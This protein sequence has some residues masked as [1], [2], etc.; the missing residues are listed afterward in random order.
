MQYKKLAEISFSASFLNIE[1]LMLSTIINQITF[2]RFKSLSS[3][4]TSALL[5]GVR[6]PV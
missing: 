6:D 1:F 2:T 3:N 4:I 5:P